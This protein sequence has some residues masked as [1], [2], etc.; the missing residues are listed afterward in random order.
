M[1]ASL[2]ARATNMSLW[3]TMRKTERTL[4]VFLAEDVDAP[5]EEKTLP[6]LSY[7]LLPP[8][9]ALTHHLSMQSPGLVLITQ[10]N[11]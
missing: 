1:S 4:S 10:R 9:D 7:S 11:P 5:Q 6:F 2:T 8:H 3:M